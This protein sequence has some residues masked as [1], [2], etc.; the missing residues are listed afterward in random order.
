MAIT[1]MQIQLVIAIYSLNSFDNV[2]D[3]KYRAN[4]CYPDPLS[5]IPAVPYTRLFFGWFLILFSCKTDRHLCLTSTPR[6]QPVEKLSS[7]VFPKNT[8][9]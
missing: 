8:T 7:S 5:E 4:S 6:K 9:T 2:I 1:L 3:V